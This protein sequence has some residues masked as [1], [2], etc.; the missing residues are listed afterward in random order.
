MEIIPQKSGSLNFQLDLRHLQ[1]RNHRI[2]S[3]LDKFISFYDAFSMSIMG[4]VTMGTRAIMNI[5]SYVYSS[6]GG[7][8]ES[9]KMVLKKGRIGD[10]FA[11]LR[12][13]HDS[14][15]LNIYTNVYLANNHDPLKNMFVKEVTDWLSGKKKL[16]HNNYGT[17]SVYLEKSESLLDVFSILNR[18]ESYREMRQRCNDHTHYNYFGNILI[19]DNQVHFPERM[20]LLDSLTKDL[21]NILIL[22]L[23]CIFKLNDHYMVSS[24]YI[25]CLD[26]GMEPE[27]DSQYWVAP[28]IQTIFTELIEK[29][30]P[31]VAKLIKENTSM[32]LS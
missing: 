22:H 27:P 14:A 13:Y 16:P 19:N 15:V 7:T 4:F 30:Q 8:L 3:D 32:K 5:D 1:F 21:E 24:D 11:L 29:N 12:K 20:K 23:A 31:D 28:F 17:M 26:V 18:D 9:I 2:F 10:A 25:D 6:M